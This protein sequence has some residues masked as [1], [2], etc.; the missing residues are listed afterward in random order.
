MIPITDENDGV[1]TTGGAVLDEARRGQP[2]RGTVAARWFPTDDDTCNGLTRPNARRKAW[3]MLRTD[4]VTADP[5]MPVDLT[6][7]AAS[8]A[9]SLDPSDRGVFLTWNQQPRGRRLQDH[10]LRHQPQ[11]G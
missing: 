10:L 8:D 6:A 11:S 2:H 9:N 4:K 3:A 5:Q 7:E 1:A